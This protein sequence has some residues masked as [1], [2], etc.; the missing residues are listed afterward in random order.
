MAAPFVRVC[1]FVRP[2]A[3]PIAP[4]NAHCDAPPVTDVISMPSYNADLMLLTHLAI[5]QPIRAQRGAAIRILL[6]L[7]HVGRYVSE[8]L[9]AWS[10]IREEG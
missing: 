1:V 5:L 7:E 10:C 9:C 6:V 3:P 8:R 4:P 2:G